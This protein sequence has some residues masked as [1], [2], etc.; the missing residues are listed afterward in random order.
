MLTDSKNLASAVDPKVRDY[1]DA[2][3]REEFLPIRDDLKQ[4][5]SAISAVREADQQR[6]DTLSAR[7]T[8]VHEIIKLSQGRVE[9]IAQLLGDKE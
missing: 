6:C 2:K 4:L 8:T 5:A 9:R 3:L 7:V 1:L